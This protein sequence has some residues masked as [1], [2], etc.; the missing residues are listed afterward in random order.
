[1]PS[2]E[3]S[4]SSHHWIYKSSSICARP[5]CL[6]S[7]P[8]QGGGGVPSFTKGQFLWLCSGSHLPLSPLGFCSY[9]IIFSPSIMKLS[10]LLG[11]LISMQ[12][13]G[14]EFYIFKKYISPLTLY[15]LQYPF[16]F[17]LLQTKAFKMFD[18]TFFLSFLSPTNH[19]SVHS[20]L[21]SF[22]HASE[23][24]HWGHLKGHVA[25]LNDIV[26]RFTF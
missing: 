22:Y 12:K 20:N 15:S 3:D 26:S 11:H 25:K 7:L 8:S 1:M 14:E 16:F 6:P 18:L 4:P 24:S 23:T 13:H 19:V 10:F 9:K 5:L 2:G 17:S 21:M